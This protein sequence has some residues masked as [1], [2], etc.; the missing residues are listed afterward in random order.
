MFW[1][2][3]SWIRRLS[4]QC[5]FRQFRRASCSSSS[6]RWVSWIAQECCQ[7]S[8]TPWRSLLTI[9][10]TTLFSYP[11]STANATLS[12]DDTSS[13]PEEHSTANSTS[14]LHKDRINGWE[15]LPPCPLLQWNHRHSHMKLQEFFM[16]FCLS[17]MTPVT[18]MSSVMWS[19]CAKS[20]KKSRR[21]NLRPSELR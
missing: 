20:L 5:V 17:H 18:E 14:C 12:W 2:L 4:Q 7:H 1:Q 9:P 13:T 10:K 15:H 21:W 3:W 11:S 6:V 19:E 8:W 16:T